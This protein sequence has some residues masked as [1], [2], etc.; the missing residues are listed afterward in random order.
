LEKRGGG[1]GGGGGERES[2]KVIMKVHITN[3]EFQCRY[4]LP[5]V[6]LI[7]LFLWLISFFRQSRVHQPNPDNPRTKATPSVGAQIPETAMAKA[8]QLRLPLLDTQE[9]SHLRSR[10]DFPDKF[11]RRKPKYLGG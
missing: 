1:G 3:I 5:T 11:T 9:N 8:L 7:Y 4:L 6:G 10:E 2:Q